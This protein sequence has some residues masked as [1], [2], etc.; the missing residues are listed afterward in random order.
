M[1]GKV[2][3]EQGP[4]DARSL[5]V[6]EK[7]LRETPEQV[8]QSLAELKEL[9]AADTT[10]RFDTSD[11]FLIM[12][13]RPT[14]FYAKSAYD[15]LK[16]IADFRKSQA[17]ILKGVSPL[18][19][20]DAFLNTKVLNVLV[21]RDQHR[22]RIL[23]MNIGDAWNPSTLDTDHFFRVLYLIHFGAMMEP[24]TQVHGAVIIM[25]F[26]N[27][28]FKQARA[29]TP[30]F[31]FRLLTFIQKA[32]PIRLKAIHIVFQ[33]MLF[34]MIW[35]L[36]KPLIEEKLSKRIFFH[37][38]DMKSLHKHIDPQ[39]LP[40]VYGGEKGEIDYGSAEWFAIFAQHDETVK[41]WQSYGYI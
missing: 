7:E 39:C 11:D 41:E 16:R 26:N 17:D 14:K 25:D 20:K 18:A 38:K 15:L 1:A 37:G 35:Q 28:G 23:T 10:L 36:F 34:K 32:M 24:M 5:E 40:R 3:L 21:D 13:L 6:A 30:T 27:L 19:E 31:A 4:L 22:R 12:F 29:F 2:G 33:P 9:L 8:Q